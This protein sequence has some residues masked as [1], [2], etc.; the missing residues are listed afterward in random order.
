M[1]PST[2]PLRM[3]FKSFSALEASNDL[4]AANFQGSLCATVRKSLPRR[5]ILWHQPLTMSHLGI[6]PKG[7]MLPNW[8]GL[9]GTG[10]NVNLG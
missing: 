9:G 7:E 2:I 10:W 5:E 4:P 1:P 6:T 3:I 8:V